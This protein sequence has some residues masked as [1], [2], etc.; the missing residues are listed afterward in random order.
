M[1]K[2]SEKSLIRQGFIGL[3]NL[4]IAIAE[5]V[6]KITGA[7]ATTLG[8]AGV[9]ALAAGATAYA[10]LSSKAGDV[11]SPADG[12]TRISTKE[13]GLFELSPKDDIVAAPGA[14]KA[15]EMAA[16]GGG[17]TTT[18]V[19]QAPTPTTTL[20]QNNEQ[21]DKTNSLLEEILNFQVKQPQLSAVGL[22]EVQ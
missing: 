19:Q 2:N 1:E 20:P 21:A 7:S 12:K 4:G 9:I 11:N 5:A 22:Y 3:K 6:A 13:G 15:L 18:I 16:K 17:N 8:I 14:S 10:F